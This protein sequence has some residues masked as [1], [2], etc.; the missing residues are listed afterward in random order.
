MNSVWQKFEGGT[1]RPVF[2]SVEKIPAGVYRVTQTHDG[3]L[4]FIEQPQF[5][6]EVYDLPGLPNAFINEQIEKFWAAKA[7]YEQY[8]FVHKRGILLY[9]P[10][11]NGKTSVITS[12]VKSQLKHDGIILCIS[13]FPTAS[14][15]LAEIK[16]IEPKR[17]LM[18][19][20]EDM[21]SLLNGDP[22]HQEPH[23]L[24]MLDGQEQVNGIVHIATTNYPETIADRF[25]KRPGRFDLIISL[26][27][28]DKNT[29]KAYFEKILKDISHP[30]LD[31]LVEKT[32]GL[33]LAYLREI[34]SSYLCLGIPVEESTERLKK[35]YSSKVSSKA[36][37]HVG[38]R[39]GYVSTGEEKKEVKKEKEKEMPK[40]VPDWPEP[41]EP[42]QPGA[43]APYQG[44][45]IT[46]GQIS[47]YTCSVCGGTS[48]PCSHWNRADLEEIFKKINTI[49]NGEYE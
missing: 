43:P 40:A 28:P 9:G 12:L 4:L 41:L 26:G 2:D 48:A 1:Y 36:N 46:D 31:Y 21:D 19:L 16:K 38:F 25:I 14:R 23:A 18:T 7:D 5:G 20:I 47:G 13:H 33:S 15:A 8:K 17:R 27:L 42:E 45:N 30:K 49:K 10:P 29:R 6:D 39:L 37:N 35:S 44:V 3:S 22:A 34:A 24:A 11:G 32:D